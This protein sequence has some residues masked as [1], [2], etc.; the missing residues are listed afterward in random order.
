MVDNLFIFVHSNIKSEINMIARVILFI[1]FLTLCSLACAQISSDSVYRKKIDSIV[2]MQSNTKVKLDDKLK[3]L[4]DC[5]IVYWTP[6]NKIPFIEGIYESVLRESKRRGNHTGC[7]LCYSKLAEVHHLREDRVGTK[8]YLDSAKVYISKVDDDMM[9]ADYYYNKASYYYNTGNK[10]GAN[11][12]FYSALIHYEKIAGCEKIVGFITSMLFTHSHEIRKMLYK[13]IKNYPPRLLQNREVKKSL[14]IYEIRRIEDKEDCF[15]NLNLDSIYNYY[16][17][18][19]K[20]SVGFDSLYYKAI[21]LSN[22]LSHQLPDYELAEQLFNELE[23]DKLE[24]SLLYL[25][26]DCK[27]LYYLRKN[28]LNDAQ[29]YWTL[30][31]EIID[32]NH[33]TKEAYLNTTDNLHSVIGS[34]IFAQ[35]GDIYKT[36]L[37]NRQMLKIERKRGMAEVSDV[38]VYYDLKEEKLKRTNLEQ[39]NKALKG[40]N[41]MAVSA[42]VLLLLS[43]A[44]MYANYRIYKKKVTLQ[45]E[46]DKLKIKLK[47]EEAMRS[48]TEKYEILSDNNLKVLALTRKEHEIKELMD[49]KSA[50]D[51]KLEEYRKK[52]EEYEAVTGNDLYSKDNSGIQRKCEIIKEELEQL[53]TKKIPYRAEYIKYLNQIRTNAI[54]LLQ[55]SYSGK[56]STLYIKYCFCFAIGMNIKD[57]ADLFSI[58]DA[59][60]RVIRSRIKSHIADIGDNDVD[61]YLHSLIIS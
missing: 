60:V 40:Q 57:V 21:M 6:I 22:V 41:I 44:L 27:A 35:R 30:C 1:Q 16:S 49:E 58:E 23:A 37:T 13:R 14:L 43:I 20:E 39:M 12:N 48:E 54:E 7:F 32:K 8:L 31:E 4:N 29:R 42:L 18:I 28:R 36:M 15:T 38:K 2:S 26:Y 34:C 10:I 53:L 33:E 52:F 11:E 45:Q 61:T 5:D 3:I 19:Q 46:E 55:K 59:S 47:E 25:Y 56:M 50:L 51:A 9:L 17:M 24:E